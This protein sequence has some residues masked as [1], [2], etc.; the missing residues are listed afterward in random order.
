MKWLFPMLLWL[1]AVEASAATLTGKVVKVADGDT[2]TI[3]VGTE[4]H[5]IRLQGIDAPERKQPYGKASGRSLS[6]L[7]AGKHVRVEYDKRDRYGRIIGVVW[8]RSPDT[9]CN[10]EPCPMTLDA[11]MYQVTV[12]MAWWYRHYAKEQTPEQRGQY[13]FAEFEAKAKKTG[14]W[15]EPEPVAPWEWRRQKRKAK[16]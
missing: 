9:R 6:A 15:Q 13:E 14:L 16:S 2:I 4:Q 10:A 11:G 7:V 12:G 5:R 8:V 3:L 1:I